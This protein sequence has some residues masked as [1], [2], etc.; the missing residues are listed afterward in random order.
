MLGFLLQITETGTT[1]VDTVVQ[2]VPQVTQPVATEETLSLWELTL[3]GGLIM[4]PIGVLSIIAIYI[5]IERFFAVQKAGREDA[6]FMNNIREFIRSGKVDSA[7]SL[8]KNTNSPYAR[9][10]HKGLL[11]L[12]KPLSDINTAI[13]NTGKLEIA[14]LEK[15]VTV[16]ATCA[17]GAPMLGFL[18]TVTGMVRAFYNMSKAG[19]NIDIGTLSG[20]IYEAMVTTVA[21]LIV[22]LIAYFCYNIIVARTQKVVNKMEAKATE[23][24]DLLQEPA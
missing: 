23:F 24:M 11:R 18:G 7:V 5:F 12:G 13:E 1:V 22:G 16:L 9:M 6:S 2:N 8:A 17:G 4:I 14:K 3:K 19:N 15:N 20:G 21:G 10:V